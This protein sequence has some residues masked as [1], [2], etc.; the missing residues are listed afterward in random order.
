MRAW[1]ER[2]GYLR[3]FGV[4]DSRINLDSSLFCPRAMASRDTFERT[5][6]SFIARRARRKKKGGEKGIQTSR[7]FT[8]DLIK[9]HNLAGRITGSSAPVGTNGGFVAMQSALRRRPAV[10]HE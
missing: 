4:E 3:I 2:R 1:E 8:M 5:I 6:S 10:T 7:S 9:K